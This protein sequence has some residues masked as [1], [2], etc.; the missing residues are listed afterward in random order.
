M[1]KKDEQNSL[2]I[3][4]QHIFPTTSA[5]KIDTI[6]KNDRN[7]NKKNDTTDSGSQSKDSRNKKDQGKSDNCQPKVKVN[8]VQPLLTWRNK[9]TKGKMMMIEN[10]TRMETWIMKK[11]RSRLCW[12][13]GQI[14][15]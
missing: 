4:K 7:V 1:R 12:K 2:S 6:T 10:I 15:V 13:Y 11:D 5:P 9:M 8:T 3:E 14:D